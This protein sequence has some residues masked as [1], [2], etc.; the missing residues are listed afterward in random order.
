MSE[1]HPL[2]VTTIENYLRSRPRWVRW[3][4]WASG[5]RYLVVRFED[6]RTPLVIIA[7][8]VRDARMAR[9][10][11]LAVERDWARVPTRHRDPYD[12][13][14]FKCPEWVVVQLRRTNLCGCLGHRHMVVKEAPFAESHEAFG[15]ASVGE[16]DIAYERV[17]AW[18]ASP[19]TDTALDTRFLEGSRLEEFRAQQFRLRML[20]IIL[21]ELNHLVFSQESESSVRERSLAFYR[22][23]LASYVESAVATLSLT[24]DRSFSRFG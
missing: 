14:L 13:I 3:R 24:I 19:L 16:M 20:S 1:E 9:Q 22:D 17:Q 15:G 21:H 18:Q 8:S 11:A 12:E 10:L 6:R 23:A 7:H 2:T 4:E 5:R